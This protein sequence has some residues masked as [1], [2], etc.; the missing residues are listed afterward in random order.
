MRQVIPVAEGKDQEIDQNRSMHK[1]LLA[2][3]EMQWLPQG[4]A[5]V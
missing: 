1:A 2:H 4:K 5:L 3:N